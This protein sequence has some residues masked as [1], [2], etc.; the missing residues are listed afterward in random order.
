MINYFNRVVSVFS[1]GTC[2]LILFE[3]LSQKGKLCPGNQFFSM[4][5]RVD[6][7]WTCF[8]TELLK[9][10]SLPAFLR[11]SSIRGMLR[12]N[13]LSIALEANCYTI[14]VT[15]CDGNSPC[16]KAEKCLS[17]YTSQIHS[18]TL[19]CPCRLCKFSFLK[20]FSENFM[21]KMGTDVHQRWRLRCRMLLLGLQWDSPSKNNNRRISYF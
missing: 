12:H 21:R 3:H 14:Q 18:K 11:T 17:S 9:K 15:V 2:K 16:N 6:M 1:L 19:F 13:I 5:M 4:L 8:S 20:I 10:V 7:K